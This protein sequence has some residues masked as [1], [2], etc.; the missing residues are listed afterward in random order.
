M[1]NKQLLIEALAVNGFAIG[2]YNSNIEM[3]SKRSLNRVIEAIDFGTGDVKVTVNKKQYVVEIV[4]VCGEYDFDMKA[5][6]AYS[7][8]YGEF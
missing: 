2:C 8:Q 5:L 1:K 4:E 3:L 6:D 7:E